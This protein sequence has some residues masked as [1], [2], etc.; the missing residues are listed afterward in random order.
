MNYLSETPSQGTLQST[1]SDISQRLQAPDPLFFGSVPHT[2]ALLANQH[3][4]LA[5]GLNASRLGSLRPGSD[6]YRYD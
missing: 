6:F 4:R 2:R 3:H 5:N 1:T